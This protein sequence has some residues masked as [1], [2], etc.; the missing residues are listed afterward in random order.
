MK[1]L[2]AKIRR[3]LN[4][5]TWITL[6][7]VFAALLI[8]LFSAAQYYYTKQLLENELE[9]KASI[10]IT[11]KAILVKSMFNTTKQ[12]LDSHETEITKLIDDPDEIGDAI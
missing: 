11:M 4:R 3:H 5:R 10:E 9:K 2:I 1:Q 12:V 6:I 8:E 7:I